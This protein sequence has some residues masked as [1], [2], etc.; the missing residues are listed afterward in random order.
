MKTYC[1]PIA[2]VIR[3]N[4]QDVITASVPT[5]PFDPDWS[6][7]FTRNFWEEGRE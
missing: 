3:L 6:K 7:M 4:Y 1:K 5:S 2:L